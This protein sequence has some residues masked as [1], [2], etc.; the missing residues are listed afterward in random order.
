MGTLYTSKITSHDT[1]NMILHDNDQ[2]IFS[3][4]ISIKFV[5]LSVAEVEPVHF[6][7]LR[8]LSFWLVAVRKMLT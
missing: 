7:P 8:W 3:H 4:D 5:V 6:V 2:R 1:N